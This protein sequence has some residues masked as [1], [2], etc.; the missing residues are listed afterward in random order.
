MLFNMQNIWRMSTA[1]QMGGR[2]ESS[3]KLEYVV[4]LLGLAHTPK[5]PRIHEQ[6]R[7]Q[8]E[9]TWIYNCAL[10]FYSLCDTNLNY[11]PELIL[12]HHIKLKLNKTLCMFIYLFISKATAY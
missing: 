5:H 11:W 6:I 4:E 2:I 8:L 1:S 12:R 9:E 10:N 7:P 3:F